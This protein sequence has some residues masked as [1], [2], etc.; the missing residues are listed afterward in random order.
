MTDGFLVGGG[1]ITGKE[2][3][4]RWGGGERR[5]V[6]RVENTTEGVRRRRRE[7]K[8]EAECDS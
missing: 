4:R 1:G 6:Q 7:R 8:R 5:E 3:G 2:I